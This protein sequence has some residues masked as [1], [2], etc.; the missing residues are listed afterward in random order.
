MMHYGNTWRVHRR[1]FHRFFNI[2][3]VEQVDDKIH[4]A[5]NIFFRRLSDSPE[6]FLN[7]VHLYVNPQVLHYLRLTVRL[8]IPKSHRIFD[9][10]DRV[11]GE[12][13]V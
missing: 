5:V 11:R 7:H 2:S 9:P 10:V 8:L 13:R 12:H 4:K 3:A 6:R 1:L